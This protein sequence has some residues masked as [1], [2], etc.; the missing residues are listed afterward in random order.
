[1]A[2]YEKNRLACGSVTWQR[3]SVYCIVEGIMRL[4]E[5]NLQ[6]KI[7]ERLAEQCELEAI[8]EGRY[9]TYFSCFGVYIYIVHAGR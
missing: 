1:V 9:Y 7:D 2:K 3:V 5:G 6:Q 8:D 4:M